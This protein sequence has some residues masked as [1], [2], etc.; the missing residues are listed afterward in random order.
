M[1]SNRNY[2][3]QLEDE[4]RGIVKCIHS[5]ATAAATFFPIGITD[6]QKENVQE[7]YVLGMSTNSSQDQLRCVLTVLGDT[8]NHAVSFN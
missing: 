5:A 1:S 4:L 6:V 3:R 7:K 2:K 8:I